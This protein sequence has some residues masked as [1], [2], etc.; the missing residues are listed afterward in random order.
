MT[1]PLLITGPAAEPVTADELADWVRQE[2]NDAADRAVMTAL[3]Q[4]AREWFEA[5]SGRELVLQTWELRLEVFPASYIELPG[6]PL[7][8]V[9]S[10]T[11][12]DGDGVTQTV[13]PGVYEVI[14]SRTPGLVRLAYGETWPVVGY[15]AEAIFVRYVTGQTDATRL[16]L[17][18]TGIKLLAAS[19]Y[20]SREAGGAI[21]GACQA[22]AWALGGHR[23]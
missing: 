18:R 6:N 23:F 17:A 7:V 12:L 13:D 19:W 9:T 15:F 5:A 11:Y 10:V 20:A 14:T 22:I 2:V 21:P 3:L 8:S 1:T 4:S 16:E